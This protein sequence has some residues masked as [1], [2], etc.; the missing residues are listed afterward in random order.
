MENDIYSILQTL[1]L[2]IFFYYLIRGL[3]SEISGLKGTINAQNETLKIMDKRIEETEKIGNIYK[4][5]INDL[6]KDLEDYKTI[7][8]QTKDEM[9]FELKNQNEEIKKKLNDTKKDIESSPNS[10]EIITHHMRILK[11][12]L[13]KNKLKHGLQRQY[14]LLK[15]SEAGG[16]SL[17]NS[18]QL[19]YQSQTVEDYLKLN[20]YN[21]IIDDN[22][23]KVAEIFNSRTAP[24]GEPIFEGFST[25]PYDE[26]NIW[27]AI[28]NNYLYISSGRLSQL[29]DEFSILK[30]IA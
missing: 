17:E 11:N 26:K 19:I 16:R 9:I 4:N 12:L 24:D 7:V 15:I 30:D 28:I 3:R 20:K 14:F 13:S 2:G 6:P 27:H 5:L 10:P 23:E 22:Y 29:K 25:I 1:G 8:T 18:V 21:L